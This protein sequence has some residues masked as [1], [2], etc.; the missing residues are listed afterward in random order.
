[1]AVSVSPAEPLTADTDVRFA[2]VI[3]PRTRRQVL[4]SVGLSTLAS[5]L[6]I[7]T[8]LLLV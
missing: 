3:W 4:Q 7:T 5:S 8:A 1:M 2:F 6:V